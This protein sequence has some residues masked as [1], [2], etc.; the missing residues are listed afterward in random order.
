MSHKVDIIENFMDQKNVE[1]K[2]I[3]L[4]DLSINTFKYIDIKE[5]IYN[6]ILNYIKVVYSEEAAQKTQQMF[7]HK[8]KVEDLMT[9]K[10]FSGVYLIQI[11]NEL[12]ELHK[13]T[14]TKIVN[15]GWI[16]NSFTE[17][18]KTEKIAR[19]IVL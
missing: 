6:S 4:E 9:N 16:Y 1:K 8:T 10:D 14:V 12:Y 13:K 19:F 18:I 3:I 17:E 7:D 15:T 11:N 2:N 5:S